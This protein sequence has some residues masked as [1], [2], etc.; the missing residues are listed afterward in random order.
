LDGQ[1]ATSHKF[2]NPSNN[3][4]NSHIYIHMYIYICIYMYICIYVYVYV[5]IY[6]YLASSFFHY[7]PWLFHTYISY[8]Y[9]IYE[10]KNSPAKKYMQPLRWRFPKLGLPQI[11]QVI[12]PGL[13]IETTMLTWGIPHDWRNPHILLVYLHWYCSTSI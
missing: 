4:S 11:I 2:N 13:S 12:R 3:P 10:G 9:I 1:F 7:N 6:I 5:C 8:I